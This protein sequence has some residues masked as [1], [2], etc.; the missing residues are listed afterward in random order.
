MHSSH[1]RNQPWATA[2]GA[3]QQVNH[4]QAVPMLSRL[5]FFRSNTDDLNKR[6]LFSKIKMIHLRHSKYISIF[7]YL[8]RILKP[9]TIAYKFHLID[10]KILR[11]Y[12]SE[13]QAVIFYKY[14]GFLYIRRHGAS[15]STS[16]AAGPVP[17]RFGWY[18]RFRRSAERARRHGRPA[19]ACSR[20]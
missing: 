11:K 14:T 9:T 15:R 19:S 5:Q 16:E 7:S 1:I 2:P 20:N 3:S 13:N 17:S 6:D 4:T 12:K 8:I 10:I 18:N